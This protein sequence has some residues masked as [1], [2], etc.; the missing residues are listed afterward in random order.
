MPEEVNENMHDMKLAANESNESDAN[1][2]DETSMPNLFKPL[3]QTPV[4]TTPVLSKL[5]EP[6]RCDK[7]ENSARRTPAYPDDK[8]KCVDD[9][10]DD[11]SS[12]LLPEKEEGFI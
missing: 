9:N 4:E 8:D 1:K 6:E 5:G 10:D 2:M 12:G 3:H 11:S 7:M